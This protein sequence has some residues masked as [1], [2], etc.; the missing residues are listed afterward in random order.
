M[1][2]IC[3]WVVDGWMRELYDWLLFLFP[4]CFFGLNSQV[5]VSLAIPPKVSQQCSGPQPLRS[6]LPLPLRPRFVN[7]GL[8]HFQSCA[9][10]VSQLCPTLCNPMDCS[11]PDSSV[12]GILQ[13]R[14]LEWVAIPS[15]RG[16]SQPR[17]QTWS[18]CIAGGLFTTEPP[19]KPDSWFTIL[20]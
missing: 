7:V 8:R 10:L 14:V 20:Y 4:I 11:P 15:S 2:Y 9:C 18:S 17:D 12:C 3:G 6:L 1:D 13:A 16:S 5:R 19:G